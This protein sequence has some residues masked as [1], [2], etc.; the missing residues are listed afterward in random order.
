LTAK[1]SLIN[2]ALDQLSSP[3]IQ[4]ALL[5]ILEREATKFILKKIFVGGGLKAWLAIFLAEEVLEFGDDK[6]IEPA[7]RAV[8]YVGDTLGG[9]TVY[10]KVDNAKDVDEWLD[11]L[12]DV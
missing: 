11:T 6:L 12:N 10:K 1:R 9:A 3:V 7:F 8:G 2:R 5:A 4:N